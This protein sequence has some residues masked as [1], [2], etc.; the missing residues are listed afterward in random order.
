M[1][2]TCDSLCPCG[3]LWWSWCSWLRG[4]PGFRS[5]FCWFRHTSFSMGRCLFSLLNFWFYVSRHTA[6]STV[7]HKPSPFFNWAGTFH[8]ACFALCGFCLSFGLFAFSCCCFLSLFCFLV[9]G[10]VTTPQNCE[11]CPDAS[12]VV[13]MDA[14]CWL[15]CHGSNSYS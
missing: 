4:S 12:T 7:T 11:A 1:F 3:L 5:E 9:F 6:D 15:L 13:S 14:P 2:Q 10:T 8:N